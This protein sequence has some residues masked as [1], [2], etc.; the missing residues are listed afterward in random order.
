MDEEQGLASPLAGGLRGIRRSLSSNIFTGR[1]VPPP[2]QPDPQTT[3]LLQQNSLSLNNV[4]TQLTNISAQISGLNGSLASI[5]ENLTVNDTLERQREAAKQNRERILAEQGLREGKESQIESRI[6][7]ALTMPVR[8]VAQKV[9]GGL[10]NLG[11][12]F[13]FLTLGWLTNS[14]I[15]VI[16]AGADKNTDLFTQLKSTFQKQLII[17][18]ATIAALTVGFKGILTGLSFL[19]TSALRIARGGLL[20]TPFAKIAAGIAAGTLLIKGAKAISPTGGPV[21]D[22]VVGAIA[23]PTAIAGTSFVKTQFAKLLDFLDTKFPKKLIGKK[24]A[25]ETA[26]N[27]AKGIKPIVEKG[28]LGF[29]RKGSRFI[30][31]VGGPLFT[32]VFNLLDGEGVGAAASA[33]AGFFAGAKAGA[34]LGATLGALVGGIGAAPGALIG[35]LIGGFLGEAAFKGIFKG[36][37]ALFGFKVGNEQEDEARDDSVDLTQE[38]TLGNVIT[39]DNVNPISLDMASSNTVYGPLSEIG[40]KNN[41]LITSQNENL[42]A[43]ITPRNPKNDSEIAKIISTM[44]EGA[45]QVITFPIQGGGGESTGG[46]G[47]TPP[48][49]N[50]NRLPQIGFDNNNIHTMY[51]TSTYGANA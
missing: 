12:F 20:R 32:F 3:N 41:E 21:G 45:P 13:T 37:K 16:N 31:R 42:V 30:S 2:A 17:A 43:S 47:V 29:I 14:L 9:Q 10:A 44:E 26:K 28:I 46:G 11:S 50:T 6:Q 4:S 1:A 34:A 18:G 24:V 39:E 51:A 48:D 7:Q 15:N 23:V 27:T 49:D 8:R 40:K 38:A 22:A 33:A 25:E 35:G 19:S 36:I 5:K